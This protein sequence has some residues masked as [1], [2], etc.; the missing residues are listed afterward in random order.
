MHRVVIASPKSPH[1]QGRWEE[2]GPLTEMGS[3]GNDERCRT[4]PI[5]PRAEHTDS[6]ARGLRRVVALYRRRRVRAPPWV[7]V[8]RVTAAKDHREIWLRG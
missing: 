6:G 4:R 8:T 5:A 1:H 7:R 3:Q 2:E